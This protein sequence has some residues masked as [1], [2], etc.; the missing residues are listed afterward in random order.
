VGKE[1]PNNTLVGGPAGGDRLSDEGRQA[2]EKLCR[3][4]WFPLYTFIRKRGHTPEQAQD[5][6]QGFF[7]VF[8]ERTR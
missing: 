4:Y 8:L 5:L 6:T 7:A 3:T 1:F 2:L